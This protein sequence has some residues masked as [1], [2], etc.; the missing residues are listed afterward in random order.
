MD[1]VAGIDAL[2]SKD[3]TVHVPATVTGSITYRHS[4]AQYFRG[5]YGPLTYSIVSTTGDAYAVSGPDSNGD[6][7]ISDGNGNMGNH[8]HGARHRHDGFSE[9]AV[10][11]HDHR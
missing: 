8:Y 1:G 2:D 3:G 10:S 5:G 11:A 9:D 7:T 4:V 6:L